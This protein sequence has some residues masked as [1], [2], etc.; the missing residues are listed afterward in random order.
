ML[1]QLLK[2]LPETYDRLLKG[3]V[4]SSKVEE[5]ITIEPH[6]P[7]HMSDRCLNDVASIPSWCHGLLVYDYEDD[8]LRF[9]HST[10]RQYLVE[11]MMSK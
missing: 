9:A 4:D 7:Y 1:Q 5:A 3:I 2:G 11:E 6:Q 8:V 10:V